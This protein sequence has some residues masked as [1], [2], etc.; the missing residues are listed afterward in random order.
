[1]GG[2]RGVLAK[3]ETGQS[4]MAISL[5]LGELVQAFRKHLAAQVQSGQIRDRT[6]T[7]QRYRVQIGLD[8]LKAKFPAGLC[9]KVSAI[10]GEIFKGY[11]TWRKAVIAAK[12]ENGSIRRDVVRDEL[13]VIRKM[14]KYALS[15]KLCTE[16]QLPVWDFTVEKQAAIRRRITNDDIKEFMET[17]ASWKQEA[18]NPTDQYHRLVLMHVVLLVESSGLRSGEVFGLRNKYAE[19]LNAD[20][21][22]VTVKADTSKVGRERSI[23]VR[24][25]FLIEFWLDQAQKFREPDDYLFSP[26]KSGNISVRDVFY[27]AYKSL[28]QRLKELDLDWIDLYH[29][30]H[31]YI[32]QRLLAGESIHLVAKA[33]GTSVSEIEKTYS[34]VL[35]EQVT[36]KFSETIVEFDDD[37]HFKLWKVKPK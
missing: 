21:L 18:T 3:V 35:T 12:R 15:Q 23:I 33:V 2:R 17:V 6:E 7:I 14:F 27:H 4:V 8:F 11:L 30:R 28:R 20:Q 25:P 24:A 36:E 19:R 5:E 31:W 29:C 34:N 16:R 10:D 22:R 32:T 13:I 26:Y 37:G 1:L 9:T